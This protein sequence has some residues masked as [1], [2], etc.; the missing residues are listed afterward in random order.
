MTFLE[1]GRGLDYFS[2]SLSLLKF[3]DSHSFEQLH[4]RPVLIKLLFLTEMKNLLSNYRVSSA[5][6]SST[7]IIS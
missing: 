7:L 6:D 1:R 4:E 3:N 5:F 2:K